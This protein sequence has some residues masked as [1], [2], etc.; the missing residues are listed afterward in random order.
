M[1]ERITGL[2]GLELYEFTSFCNFNQK[3]LL[4]ASEYEIIEKVLE[5][6]KEYKKT[7]TEY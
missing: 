2:K 1:L 7:P 6:L 5:K 4:R 3:F